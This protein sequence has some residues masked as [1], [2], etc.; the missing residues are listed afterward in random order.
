MEGTLFD[1]F[2]LT[3]FNI[4]YQGQAPASE[5]WLRHRLGY[6]EQVCCPSVRSQTNQDFQWIVLLDADRDEWFE[7]EIT[8]LSIG[9]FEPVWVNGIFT[10]KTATGI[11]AARSSADWL[12]TSRLDNDDAISRD[13]IQAVQDCFDGRMGFI[14]FPS[15]L[16]L[17][18]SGELFHRSDLSNPFV[19]LIERRDDDLGVYHIRHDH[20]LAFGKIRQVR[21]RPM[22]L[23]MIHD[24][25]AGNRAGGVRANPDLL[26]YFDVQVSAK[27]TS[28]VALWASQAKTSAALAWRVAQSPRRLSVVGRI[29][30]FVFKKAANL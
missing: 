18:D 30:L 14:N 11:T 22:W 15:G 1:H 25:N 26:K 7:R 13:Y 21:S 2:V 19:S 8:R 20:A 28:W 5:G 27:P 24:R 10:P 9:L 3:R 29:S 12:I 4:R 6:F 16:Q 17:T 23:Q